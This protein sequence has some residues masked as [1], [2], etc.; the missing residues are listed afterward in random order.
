[1]DMRAARRAPKIEEKGSVE[2]YDRLR[3]K[4]EIASALLC[5]EGS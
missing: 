4:F 3:D 1:M 2:I 5:H